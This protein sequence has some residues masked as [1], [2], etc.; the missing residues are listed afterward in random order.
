[1][2]RFRAAIEMGEGAEHV[3]S[4]WN[5]YQDE[6]DQAN[7]VPLL[8]VQPLDRVHGHGIEA[9]VHLVL[10]SGDSARRQS[11]DPLQP[12]RLD[13]EVFPRTA[14]PDHRK[15]DGRRGIGFRAR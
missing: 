12:V 2:S 6:A 9:L 11:S 15:N 5:A 8:E 10:H 4:V 13:L 1:M 14:S 7:S 3:F